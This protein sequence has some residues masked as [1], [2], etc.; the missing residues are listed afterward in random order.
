VSDSND[1]TS[2]SSTLGGRLRTAREAAGL[3]ISDI[4]RTT[5]V[6]SAYLSAL[7][8]G[9]YADLPE[10]VYSRNFVRLFATSVSL[11]VDETLEIYQ[12]ERRAALGTTTL[13]QRLEHDRGIARRVSSGTAIP[14]TKGPSRIKGAPPTL[15]ANP[16]LLG[17]ILVVVIAL[18]A[19]WGLRQ[20]LS[21]NGAELLSDTSTQGLSSTQRPPSTPAS[22]AATEVNAG[23]G[24]EPPAPPEIVSIDILSTP[25]GA[26]VSLDGFV[27]AG[28]TPLTGELVSARSGR[29]IEVELAGFQPLANTVDILEDLRLEFTLAPLDAG[30]N[31]ANGEQLSSDEIIFTITE[32]SWFEAWQSTSRNVGERLAYATAQP[33]TVYRFTLPVYVHVGNAGGVQVD[34]AGQEAAAFG[35][36]G[37]V[38]GRAF[39]QRG[40]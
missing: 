18:L 31:G 23:G 12:R 6:R 9:R 34:L 33:G 29:T 2:T 40:D 25:P 30:T 1:P 22:S 19:G 5:H 28:L 35:G 3:E 21:G 26:T 7:E 14:I 20:M 39:E 36:Q 11:P 24:S 38:I 16:Y 15:L 27:L 4:A 8:E 37:G 17:S 13:D 10:D 32:T